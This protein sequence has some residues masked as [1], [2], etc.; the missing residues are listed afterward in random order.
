MLGKL[1]TS[2]WQIGNAAINPEHPYGEG[3]STNGDLPVQVLK[4]GHGGSF[5]NC[6]FEIRKKVNEI[7]WYFWSLGF[8]IH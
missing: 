5:K 2:A 8:L 3:S 6:E 7:L 1:G 4:E